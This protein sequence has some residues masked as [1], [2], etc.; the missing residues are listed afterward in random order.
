MAV[1]NKKPSLVKATQV[2]VATWPRAVVVKNDTPFRFTEKVKSV[3]LTA[4]SE[5]TVMVSESELMR[6]KH[7]FMQLNLLN[8]WN[9]GL[10]VVDSVGEENGDV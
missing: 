7:N 9:N 6:I 4:H 3:I 10:T 8:N 5:Q 1:K 2:P